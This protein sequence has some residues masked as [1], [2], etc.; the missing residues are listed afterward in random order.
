MALNPFVLMLGLKDL[1]FS[2]MDLIF[3]LNSIPRVCL[4]F[5]TTDSTAHATSRL[6]CKYSTEKFKP[7]LRTA[8]SESVRAC[9][10]L[11]TYC[12]ESGVGA[13]VT[14]LMIVESIFHSL[15]SFLLALDPWNAMQCAVM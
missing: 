1:D 3:H 7:I 4:S 9:F 14:V 15:L 11:R 5:E 10:E 2:N 12:M 6:E 8:S 13:E